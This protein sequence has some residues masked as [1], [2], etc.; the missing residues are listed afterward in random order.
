MDGRPMKLTPEDLARN[1]KL[2][3]RVADAV[4]RDLGPRTPSSRAETPAR[5]R[6]YAPDRAGDHARYRCHACGA[7]NRFYAPAERHAD[8]H[9]GGRIALVSIEQAPQ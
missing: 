1:P 3:A 8:S 9:G 6:G 2:R 4:A 5:S 7:L